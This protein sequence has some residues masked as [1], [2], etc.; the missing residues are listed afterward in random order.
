[1]VG[2]AAGA[3]KPRLTVMAAVMPGS[4]DRDADALAAVGR[5]WAMAVGGAGTSPDLAR[6]VG[7]RHLA[8]DPV[9]AARELLE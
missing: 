9:S 3:V 2:E 6:R 1:M 8:G 5:R 4:L 7:A